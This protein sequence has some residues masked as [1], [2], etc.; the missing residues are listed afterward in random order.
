MINLFFVASGGA[1]G[2]SLRFFTSN[3][4]KNF[5]PSFPLGTLLVNI[6]GSFLIGLLMNFLEN[7]HFPENFIRYFFIIGILGSYTTFSAF[8]FE[9]I[10]LFNNKKIMISCFY[11]LLSIFTCLFSAFLGYNINKIYF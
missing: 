8:S 11:I 1:I 10:D 4:F 2:A 6:I 3:L 9:V 7:K 5:Y